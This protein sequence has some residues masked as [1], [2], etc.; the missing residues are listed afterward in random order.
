MIIIKNQS[1]FNSLGLISLLLLILVPCVNAADTHAFQW[2]V[3]SVGGI[4]SPYGIAYDTAGN[5]YATDQVN[6]SVWKFGPDGSFQM[7]WGSLGSGNGYFNIPWGVAVNSSGYVYVADSGNNR[8]QIFTSSGDYVTQWGSVGPG[9]G[10]FN[11]PTGIASGRE[12]ILSKGWWNLT[13]RL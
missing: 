5:I 3:P 8:V 6:C 11:N 2:A 4:N 13:Q 10:L 1:L 9:D 7:K 12:T